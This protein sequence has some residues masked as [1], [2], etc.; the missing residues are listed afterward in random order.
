MAEDMGEK[1]ELP[2]PRRLE[3]AREKGQVPK[4]QD[5]SSAIDLIGGLIII[6]VLGAFVAASLTSIMRLVLD[7]PNGLPSVDS[8]ADLLRD[9]AMRGGLA[10]APILGAVLVV[11]FIS[12]FI[13]VGPLLTGEPLRPKFDRL[14]PIAGF[15]RTFGRRGLAKTVLNA[16]KMVVVFVVAGLML[17]GMVGEIA[18]LPRLTPLAAFAVLG[19]HALR[20]LLTLLALLLAVGVIDYLFQ[21]WQHTR[22]LKMT[23]EQVKDE[24]RSMEGDPKV[25]AARQRMARQIALQRINQ[26]VPRADVVVTNPTHFSIAIKYDADTMAAPRVVAKGADFLALRIRQVAAANRVPMVERPPLARALY[27]G[28]EVGREVP[29]EMYQAVAEVLAFVYRLEAEA[30]A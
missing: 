20:L 3:E 6:I 1:T 22:D 23:K 4:S 30:A 8:M 26:S 29:P 28:C 17:S 14:D 10:V 15:K 25:K 9:V 2:T 21:R 11:G 27:A 18:A 5:L 7:P 13:Q 19:G 12:H 24:R 16:L